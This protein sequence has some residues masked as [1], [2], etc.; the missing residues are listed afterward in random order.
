[1]LSHCQ[2]VHL[3]DHHLC[4]Q[5]V[6]I[7]LL[8]LENHHGGSAMQNWNLL[9]VASHKQISWLKVGSALFTEVSHLMAK[10]LLSSSTNLLAPKVMLSFAQRWRS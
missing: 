2:E 5:Y 7:R 10:Q 1:M 9:L 8:Y 6:S 4:V 3:P